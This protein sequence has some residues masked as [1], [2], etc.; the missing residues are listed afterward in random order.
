MIN[1]HPRRLDEGTAC[2][3]SGPARDRVSCHAGSSPATQTYLRTGDR[4]IPRG[5][6]ADSTVPRSQEA[7]MLV[8]IVFS[9]LIAQAGASQPSAPP[10]SQTESPWPPAGVYRQK[11]P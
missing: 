10:A 3:P 2:R 5:S 11:D 1:K 8:P 6:V 4:T 7:M 9:I